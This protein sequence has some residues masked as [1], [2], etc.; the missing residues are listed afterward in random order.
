MFMFKKKPTS[1]FGWQQGEKKKL[2]PADSFLTCENSRAT[3]F[4]KCFFF[5]AKGMSIE[6]MSSFHGNA[7]QYSTDLRGTDGDKN[8]SWCVFSISLDLHLNSASMKHIP[9]L[10]LTFASHL[11]S[12]T[13][14]HQ[15]TQPCTSNTLTHTLTHTRWRQ[16]CWQ[17]DKMNETLKTAARGCETL[18]R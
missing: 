10:W 3:K 17:G 13:T 8:H 7:E 5:F 14:Q 9:C 12:P 1:N 4:K 11:Y 16:G 6:I 15:D 2:N 18:H